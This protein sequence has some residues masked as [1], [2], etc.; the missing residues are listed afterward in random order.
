MIQGSRQAIK[1]GA[2]PC[3]ILLLL[4]LLLLFIFLF[5]CFWQFLLMKE[6]IK[7]HICF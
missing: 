1:G 7:P 4:F 5:V 6:A 2:P 3:W